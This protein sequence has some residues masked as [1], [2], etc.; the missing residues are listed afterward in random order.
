MTLNE[1]FKRSNFKGYKMAPLMS[2]GE[3]RSGVTYT[4]NMGVDALNDTNDKE[5][6]T[7]AWM[8]YD[9]ITNWYDPKLRRRLRDKLRRDNK[10]AEKVV[11]QPEL[12]LT[13]AQN[14]VI[15][16]PVRKV[17]NDIDEILKNNTPA[18]RDLWLILSALRGPDAGDASVAAKEVFTCFLRSKTFPKTAEAKNKG[19]GVY[20]PEFFYS[21]GP[22]DPHEFSEMPY[23]YKH[24][25]NSAAQAL[26]NRNIITRDECPEQI[27][28]LIIQGASL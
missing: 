12:P 25:L 23:H 2:S 10:P 26:V 6:I 20:Y 19:D 7:A 27:R 16:D 3:N 13:P 1:W 18:A 28:P 24:H 21:T 14:N 22:V 4:F 9:D 15:D 17:L 8:G 5:R 11:T